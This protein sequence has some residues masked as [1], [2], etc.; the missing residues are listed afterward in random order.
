LSRDASQA[1]PLVPNAARFLFVGEK[2]SPTAQRKG[3]SWDDGRVAARTLHEALRA[4]GIEPSECG[5]TNLFG[6]TADAPEKGAELVARVD[7]LRAVSRAGVIVVALGTKVARQL[8]RHSVPHVPLIH[9]A[10]RGQI[11]AR[12]RYVA[13]VGAVLI[14]ILEKAA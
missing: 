4:T 11:R 3:W 5:F 9:P 13:H 12:E 10:A 7:V 14:P 2:P 8:E 6:Q 1:E